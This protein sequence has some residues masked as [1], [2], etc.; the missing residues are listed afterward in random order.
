MH[1]ATILIIVTIYFVTV[2]SFFSVHMILKKTVSYTDF[3]R[4]IEGFCMSLLA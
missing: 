2:I 1:G 4:Y 3:V